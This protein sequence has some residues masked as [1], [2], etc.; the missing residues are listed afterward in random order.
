MINDQLKNAKNE[1]TI[2]LTYIYLTTEEKI[3]KNSKKKEPEISLLIQIVYGVRCD[4]TN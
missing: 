3:K 1:F 4:P 2:F